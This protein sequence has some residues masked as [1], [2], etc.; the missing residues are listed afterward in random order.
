MGEKVAR[1]EKP[2]DVIRGKEEEMNIITFGAVMLLVG[3]LVNAI[4]TL[5]EKLAGV[6]GGTPVIQIVVGALSIVLGLITLAK[7]KVLAS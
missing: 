6:F 5:S 4:P 3:G 1:K 7:K 2:L